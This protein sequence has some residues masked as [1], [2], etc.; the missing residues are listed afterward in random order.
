MRREDYHKMDN[1]HKKTK[2]HGQVFTPKY[3]VEEML[4]Y[5]GYQGFSI[6]GK[7]IMDNS[8]G[9]GAF[10]Q[11]IIT[12][13]C[14]ASASTNRRT[15]D[16]RKDLEKFIHGI[17]TD[18]NALQQCKESLD[19]IAQSYGIG[20]VKWDLHHENA[21]HTERFNGK[22]DFVV[23]NPPYVRVHNLGLSYAEVKQSQFTQ[24]GMTD[25]YLAFFGLGLNM[26]S[27]KGKLCYIIPSSWLGSV[28]AREMRQYILQEQNLV[29]LTDLGHF[30]AFK[31]ATAYTI[32]ALF[33]KSKHDKHFDY[34]TFDE[35]T[36]KRTFQHSISLEDCCIDNCFY[37][38]DANHL[39]WLREIKKKGIPQYAL[40]KNG[41][42]TLADKVFI[43][44]D[45]PASNITIRALKASTGKWHRCLFPYDKAG[46][47]LPPATALANN[48]VAAHLENHKTQL[49]KGRK[50]TTAFYAYGRTQ[51]LA[52]VWKPKLAVN[53]LIR[54][55][56]DLKIELVKAG[57]AIY[58]GLY[59]TCAPSIPLESIQNILTD[60]KLTEYVKLL[61]KYKSGGYYTFNSKDL[62]QY[63]NYSLTHQTSKN[64]AEQQ[65][66]FG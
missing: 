41:L 42:A 47:L 64:H 39:K 4:D 25:L 3:L 35:T 65:Y 43:G 55:E 48:A 37:L 1:Q 13:Y 26:L 21:L 63:I 16:T 44:N 6:I 54:T 56:K 22:M 49:L 66:F 50:E 62:Q 7:H 29:S 31:N 17:D 18:A 19:H 32:I 51:A 58:S 14:E 30:Q 15:S 33:A 46:K 27:P 20:Q 52:D 24:H 40:V 45:I 61:K 8:C 11:S 23:G 9:N 28:A 10:L 34:Y 57:E 5:A 36:C 38:S 60:K 2:Q 59:I 53:A 12:R